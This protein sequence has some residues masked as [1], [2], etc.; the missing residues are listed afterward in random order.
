MKKKMHNRK[1][2]LS[3]CIAFS[4]YVLLTTRSPARCVSLPHQSVSWQTPAVYHN[5]IQL[6]YSQISQLKD[7]VLIDCPSSDVREQAR[8]SGTSGSLVSSTL[9]LPLVHWLKWLPES[10]ES[11]YSMFIYL[12]KRILY[13]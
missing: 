5:S 12:L 10:R 8:A 6:N 4:S 3:K 13:S 9:F 7:A 1:I 11:L 2:P